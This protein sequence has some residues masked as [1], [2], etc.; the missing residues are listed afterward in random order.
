MTRM[1]DNFLLSLLSILA[2]VKHLMYKHFH[3]INDFWFQI[4]CI[5]QLRQNSVITDIEHRSDFDTIF[6]I[7]IGT[8]YLTIMG[9]LWSLYCEQF[10]ENCVTSRLAYTLDVWET[11]LAPGMHIKLIGPWE[12][13]L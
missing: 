6:E 5:Q 12:M 9:E 11:R 1:E 13:W 3:W 8:P 10:G 4:S 2:I 7:E